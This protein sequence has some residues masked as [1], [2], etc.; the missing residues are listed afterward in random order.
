[1]TSEVLSYARKQPLFPEVLDLNRLGPEWIETFSKQGSKAD[2]H[3]R[4]ADAPAFVRIDEGRL[5]EAISHLLM[6][7]AEA[8]AKRIVLKVALQEEPDADPGEEEECVLLEIVDD[9]CGMEP[10]ILKKCLEPFFTTKG[11]SRGAGMGL[12]MVQGFVKQ[13]GGAL[14][15]ASRP[16][17]G[18]RVRLRFARV[19][20]APAA[21]IRATREGKRAK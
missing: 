15:I 5:A 17:E 16:G 14:T 12:S 11:P 4:P 8:G 13:S 10:E 2:L 19:P 7:C 3:W 1:L 21:D 6:N 9:G 20:P 18:T